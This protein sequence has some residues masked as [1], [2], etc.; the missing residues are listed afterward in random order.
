MTYF[1]PT[2]TQTVAGAI[3]PTTILQRGMLAALDQ[4]ESLVTCLFIRKKR[5]NLAYA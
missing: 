4:L 2:I 3:L 5:K 1:T